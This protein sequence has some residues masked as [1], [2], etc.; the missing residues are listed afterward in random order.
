MMVL[1]L[2]LPGDT[3]TPV[4]ISNRLCCLGS[5]R[6]KWKDCRNEIKLKYTIVRHNRKKHEN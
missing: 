4:E 3:S 1:A 6:L 2:R 5:V